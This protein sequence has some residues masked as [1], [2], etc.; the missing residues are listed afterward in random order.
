M[1]YDAALAELYQAPHGSFVDERKRLATALKAAGDKAGAAQ[2]GKRTRPTISAWVVN[3]L[4]W[5]AGDAFKTLLHAAAALRDG[6]LSANAA[7][8]DALVKLRTR[9]AAMLSD[10][11]HAATESTLRRVAQTIAAIAATG[12][13]EPDAP[14]TL[15]ADRDPPGFDAAMLAPT[16]ESEGAAAARKIVEAEQEKARKAAA[17]RKAM[18][19]ST[20]VATEDDDEEDDSETDEDEDEDED[21]EEETTST[22]A[23]LARAE[24]PLGPDVKELGAELKA[25]KVRLAAAEA[26][27]EQLRAQ[28]AAAKEEIAEARRLVD[29]LQAQLDAA[30]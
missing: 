14:G 30:D 27:A 9:A 10:A 11:G 8:R 2:L 20:P 15:S 7:H 18:H 3:Q 13:W 19:A 25:A 5:H 4:W 21:D 23:P 1:D 22:P 26:S 6:D 12:S 17:V 28:L 24:T 16:T 29:D